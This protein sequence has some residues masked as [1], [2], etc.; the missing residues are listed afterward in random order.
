MR[1]ILKDLCAEEGISEEEVEIARAKKAARKGGFR[2]GRYIESVTI[3][4]EDDE[5]A[6]YCRKSPEKYPERIHD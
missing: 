1:Q 4:D 6:Q 5:W 3:P 2:E